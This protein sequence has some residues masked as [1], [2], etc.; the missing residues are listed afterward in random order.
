MES[1]AIEVLNFEPSWYVMSWKAIH[2][3]PVTWIS[4]H[5]HLG[6]KRSDGWL[7][8]RGAKCSQC[9]MK[10]P[11]ELIGMMNMMNGLETRR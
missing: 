11:V 2:L 10:F 1:E 5:R 6:T 8:Q 9:G 4:M 7:L 3:A